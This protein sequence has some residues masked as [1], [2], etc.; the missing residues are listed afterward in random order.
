MSGDG[1][2]ARKGAL[3]DSNPRR[4]APFFFETAAAQHGWLNLA[5]AIGI[6]H[7]GVE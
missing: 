4:T 6:G 1:L 2:F 7:R 3:Q 5:L